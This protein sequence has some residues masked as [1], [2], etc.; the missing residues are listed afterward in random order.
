MKIP[1]FSGLHENKIE[2]AASLDRVGQMDSLIDV[3]ASAGD[4]GQ[5][6]MMMIYKSLP[7]LGRPVL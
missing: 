2:V 4:L 5:K 7:A 3:F 1:A 6:S